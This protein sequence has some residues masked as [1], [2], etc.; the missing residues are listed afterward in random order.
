MFSDF[1]YDSHER[2]IQPKWVAAH[3]S[4]TTGLDDHTVQLSYWMNVR[5]QMLSALAN[6]L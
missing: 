3:R 5:T 1:F 4:G 6:G 2:V